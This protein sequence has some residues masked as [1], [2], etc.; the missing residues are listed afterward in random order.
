MVCHSYGKAEPCLTSGGGAATRQPLVWREASAHELVKYINAVS[1]G[2]LELLTRVAGSLPHGWLTSVARLQFRFPVLKR[3]V[4]W[5]ANR[6]RNRNGEISKGV[7][8]G[9]KFNPG[10]ANAG[11]RLGT[12]EPGVQAALTR[13]VQPRM[14]VYD[15]GANVG[16][17]SVIA[18]RLVGPEGQVV[19][20]E[21][22]LKNCGQLTLN[23]QLNNFTNVTVRCEAL[24]N[25]N[26]FA[27][28][29]ATL[30]PTLGRLKK[31]GAPEPGSDEITVAVRQLDRLIID[32]GLPQPGLI[33]MDV[34]G[35]E[36]DVLLG[37]SETLAT[38]RPLLLIELHGT[39]NPVATLLEQQGYALHVLGNRGCVREA[40]WNAHLIAVPKERADLANEI[41]ALTDP[42]LAE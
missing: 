20:F 34:E 14:T 42:V 4:G 18:A 24:G 39:N 10:S 26:G 23:A 12:S 31:F 33:K 21:P 9:L 22:V 3:P 11:Y 7:G 6:F 15:I 37:A 29:F 13:L 27:T 8:R 2:K 30:E 32:S 1:K 5:L 41:R 19:A 25:E 28:F 17:F 38:A 35:A 40:L 36:V 16:F